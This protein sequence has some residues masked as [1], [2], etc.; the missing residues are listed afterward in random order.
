MPMLMLMMMMMGVHV[1]ETRPTLY[2]VRNWGASIA[3]AYERHVCVW[4][5]LVGVRETLRRH[6]S[7]IG[8]SV[9][10]SVLL[11][12][13]VSHD[14]LVTHSRCV[15]HWH[16]VMTPPIVLVIYALSL[17]V[18]HPLVVQWYVVVYKWIRPV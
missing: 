14:Y 16:V 3:G 4:V 9:D 6:H 2:V 13:S 5:Q 7:V 12:Q 8:V 15:E 17:P 1:A 10:D 11:L 18:V